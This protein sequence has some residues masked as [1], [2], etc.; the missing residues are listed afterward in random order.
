MTKQEMAAALTPYI[1]QSVEK[2][3]TISL[4]DQRAKIKEWAKRNG[5]EL[6]PEV[7]DEGVSSGKP[8]RER[9]LANVLED[10]RAGRAAGVIVAYS[11]RLT[12]EKLSAQM[13]ITEE[14]VDAGGRVVAIGK[15]DTANEGWETSHVN[16]AVDKKAALKEIRDRWDVAQEMAV[17]RGVHISPR[18]PVG[19]SRTYVQAEKEGALVFD[20]KTG[21]PVNVAGPLTPNGDAPAVRELYRMRC[22]RPRATWGECRKMFEAAGLGPWSPRALKAVVKNRV[23]LG[24]ARYGTHVNPTAHPALVDAATWRKAQSKPGEKCVKI[25]ETALLG[26]LIYCRGCGGRMSPIS[27]GTKQRPRYMCRTNRQSS[28]TC[29]AP[30]SC[31]QSDLDALVGRAFEH[32]TGHH[33]AAGAADVDLEPLERD[34]LTARSALDALLQAVA[35]ADAD[36]VSVLVG[37]VAEKRSAVETA[38]DALRD[39]QAGTGLAREAGTIQARLREGRMDVDEKRRWLREWDVRVTVRQGRGVPLATRASFSWNPEP[40]HPELVVPMSFADMWDDYAASVAA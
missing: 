6:L 13:E 32:V 14:F 22:L 36:T 25:G 28:G 5:I 18:V 39:A 26:G 31:W 12:R 35:E 8:W 2:E 1:R 20:K 7:V 30:A 24:E 9:K 3:V 11:N 38:E 33:Y 23:N 21:E 29:S 37:A 4:A 19:Y 16:D 10:V 34:V 15:W 40:L 27:G 17:A